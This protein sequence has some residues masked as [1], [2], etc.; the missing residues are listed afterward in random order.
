[1]VN[2]T[3]EIFSNRELELLNL[4]TGFY[5]KTPI[6]TLKIL[7]SIESICHKID[8]DTAS[9]IRTRCCALL[10]SDSKKRVNNDNDK[11]L[12][13]IKKIKKNH[14]DSLFLKADKG[15]CMVIMDSNE[16]CD[17]MLLML[18]DINTYEIV[19]EDNFMKNL[20]KRNNYMK[21]IL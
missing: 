14:P 10:K 15:R 19:P 9:E 11:E 21:H 2:L 6:N 3:N 8:K 17:K 20:N 13:T 16:Y 12:K 1:M 5:P 7:G 4:G 18:N